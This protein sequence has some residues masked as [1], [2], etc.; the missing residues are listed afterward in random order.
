MREKAV[1]EVQDTDAKGLL[2][3]PWLIR[4]WIAAGL[5]SSSTRVTP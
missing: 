4:E 2:L 1:S 3:S 5:L